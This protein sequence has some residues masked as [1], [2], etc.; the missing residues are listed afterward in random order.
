MSFIEELTAKGWTELTPMWEYAKGDW[1]IMFDTGAWMITTTKTNPRVFDVH[2]PGK[3]EERWTVNLIEHL[4][5]MEDERHRLRKALEA[6]RDN[7]ASSAEARATAAA[8]LKQCCHSWLVNLEVPE[9][10][11]GRIYC[12]ICGQKD[13]RESHSRSKG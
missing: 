2:V 13:V 4:C 7:P 1:R 9:G 6:V 5:L 3:H 8:A 11:V 12:P 10:Q